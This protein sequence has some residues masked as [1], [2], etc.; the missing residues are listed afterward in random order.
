M[1][2]KGVRKADDKILVGLR[3]LGSP[4]SIQGS[5]TVNPSPAVRRDEP[6]CRRSGV[7]QCK[8]SRSRWLVVRGAGLSGRSLPVQTTSVRVMALALPASSRDQGQV[9]AFPS[10]SAAPLT[11]LGGEQESFS[12]PLKT[13]F[14]G[15]RNKDRHPAVFDHRKR[16]EGRS[17]DWKVTVKTVIVHQQ[18][19]CYVTGCECERS[20][21][22]VSWVWTAAIIVLVLLLCHKSKWSSTAAVFSSALQ[23]YC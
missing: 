2:R 19:L 13:H 15:Y 17:F 7:D 11:G 20:S 8:P 10:R 1:F 9:T 16:A 6:L 21:G 12:V 23:L 18:Q 14:G 4:T 5:V 22:R 3:R